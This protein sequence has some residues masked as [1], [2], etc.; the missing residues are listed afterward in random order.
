MMKWFKARFLAFDFF[1]CFNNFEKKLSGFIRRKSQ[2]I[3]LKVSFQNAEDLL[4]SKSRFNLAYI[5]LFFN[6]AQFAL[7]RFF[8]HIMRRENHRVNH[9][10]N[11]KRATNNGAESSQEMVERLF[12]VSV[13][14]SNW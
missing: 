8:D 13:F 10:S 11:G 4:C 14:D 5:V 3:N 12:L 2:V 9:T 6:S 7:L 1:K